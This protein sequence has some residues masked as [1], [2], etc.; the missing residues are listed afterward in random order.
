M[1]CFAVP[2]DHGHTV[3]EMAAGLENT[4]AQVRET[5]SPEE[6]AALVGRVFPDETAATSMEIAIRHTTEPFSEVMQM[7]SVTQEDI[8]GA[9]H[10]YAF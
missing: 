10:P 2:S 9:M 3:P 4:A 8:E 7:M 1:G 6:A 5:G